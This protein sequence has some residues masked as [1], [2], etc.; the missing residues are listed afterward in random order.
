MQKTKLKISGMSCQHCV[1]TV[2]DVLTELEGVQRAKVN[3]RKGEAI[4]HFDESYITIV[5]L[6]EAITAAGFEA[7]T[8]TNPLS[9][10][11]I[12]AIAVVL[13]S[14]IGCTDV[15][16]TGPMLTVDSVDRYLNSLGED[17]ICLHDGFD[18]IC[19][20]VVPEKRNGED[21][22][23]PIVHIHPTSLIYMFYYEDQPILRAERIMD[24]T[25]ITQELTDQPIANGN[26]QDSSN[27]V[28]KDWTIQ[29]YYPD[30]FPE[31]DRGTT[32]ETSGLDIR[33]VEGMKIGADKQKDLEIKDFTQIDGLDS[34]RIVQFSIETEA[35]EITIQVDGLF[36][37]HTAI[38]YINADSIASNEGN[39]SLQ[40]QPLQ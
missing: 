30:A 22:N 8:K 36:T 25:Q 18:T 24:T 40:L 12:S 10:K 23:I 19:I 7:V 16:Y 37:D 5:N 39:S 9:L 29:I 20:K 21:D 13:F 35:Q 26:I 28:L 32:P 34:S 1:K 11:S 17:T 6:T 4:V 31:A 15:P 27:T 2:T 3:L 38:F 14:L 33:I